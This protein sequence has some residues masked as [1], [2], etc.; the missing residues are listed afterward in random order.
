MKADLFGY[1]LGP[2]TKPSFFELANTYQ[3]MN[4]IIGDIRDFENLKNVIVDCK[5]E[6]IIHMAAQSVVR[7]SYNHPVETYSTNV[8]G[9]VNLLEAIR[10]LGFPC[11]V[12]NVTTDKCYDNREWIWGY[13]ESDRM[14]GIDPYSN[15]KACSELVTSAFRESYFNAQNFCNHKVAI[16]TARAGNV[17][18][19]GDWT[20]DQL[21]PD[22]IRAFVANKPALIRY[23]GSIR[24]WQFVLDAL[25]GYLCLAEKLQTEGAKFSEAW[26]FGPVFQDSKTVSWVADELSKLWGEGACW[27][28]DL[29]VHPHETQVLKLDSSKARGSLGW[30]SK[31]PLT[32]ALEWV[33]EWYKACQRKEDIREISIKQISQYENIA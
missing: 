28:T 30:R 12:V 13:R 6:I 26:N 4:S 15:S 27:Q 21:I 2:P 16:A 31:V 22:I 8:I 23:P 1:S 32:L 18:G 19:G 10:Q 5:P 3:G 14:G 25:N 7:Y 17:I 20:N 33:V 29:G 24:P 11:A 9:T